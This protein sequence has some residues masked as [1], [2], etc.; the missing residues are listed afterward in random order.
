MD[1]QI[2]KQMFDMISAFRKINNEIQAQTIQTL[3]AVAMHNKKEMPMGDLAKLLGLSQASVSRNV[4][5]FMKVDRHRNKGPNLMD[6]REDPMERR[7]KLVSLTNKGH[8]FF[9]ELTN[10]WG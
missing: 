8:M 4:S 6:T 1:R 3:L 7:R 10:I 5:S 9:S 2:G